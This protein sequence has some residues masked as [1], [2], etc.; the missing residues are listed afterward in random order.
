MLLTLDRAGLDTGW[1]AAFGAVRLPATLEL[2]TSFRAADPVCRLLRSGWL[3]LQQSRIFR[4]SLRRYRLCGMPFRYDADATHHHPER[5][6]MNRRLAE[7]LAI[8]LTSKVLDSNPEAL[9]KSNV[10]DSGTDNALLV[11]NFIKT[12]SERLGADLSDEM[13]SQHISF[14][15]KNG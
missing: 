5:K 13:V 9:L 1:V 11:A 10:I 2:R 3:S 8:A 14:L 15:I 12:L 6:N 4:P 7:T